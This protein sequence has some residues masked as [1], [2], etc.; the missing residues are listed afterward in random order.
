MAPFREAFFAAAFV[1]RFA[2]VFTFF[3]AFATFFV[4]FFAALATFFATRL[5]PVATCFAA[6][7]A[8]GA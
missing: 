4:S 6:G 8:A 3:A 7:F 2:A 1:P 5:A